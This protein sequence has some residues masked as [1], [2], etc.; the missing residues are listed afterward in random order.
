MV[1]TCSCFTLSALCRAQNSCYS[2]CSCPP[3]AFN[4]VCGSD[5]VEYIS[6]CHAGCTNFTTDPNNTHRVQ[7]SAFAKHQ[8]MV[9][10]IN[11]CRLG[12]CRF[13][14]STLC[15]TTLLCMKKYKSLKHACDV[16]YMNKIDI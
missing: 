13:M 7:V 2:N 14:Y 11:T 1:L 12:C 5:G 8:F 9:S 6:P 3:N 15:T 10:C 16:E 4:P